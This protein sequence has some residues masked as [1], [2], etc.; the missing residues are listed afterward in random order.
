M[1]MAVSQAEW[2]V[3]IKPKFRQF[4]LMVSVTIIHVRSIRKSV[5]FTKLKKPGEETKNY[6]NFFHFQF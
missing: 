3:S 2:Y 1:V 6:P 5:A 4:I